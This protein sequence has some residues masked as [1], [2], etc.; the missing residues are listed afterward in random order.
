MLIVGLNTRRPYDA[1]Y[2]RWLNAVATAFSNRLMVVLQMEADAEIM[3]ERIRLDKAKS[4]FFMTV[5]HGEVYY[6]GVA[7][8]LVLIGVVVVFW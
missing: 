2:A 1:D 3:R 7:W 5:S 8:V 4:K 6:G